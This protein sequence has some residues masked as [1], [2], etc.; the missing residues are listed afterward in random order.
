MMCKLTFS[1]AASAIPI[2]IRQEMNGTARFIRLSLDMKLS[3]KSLKSARMSK[4][5]KS[6]MLSQW[7][8]WWIPVENAQV[9]R[10]PGSFC[11]QFTI[12]PSKKGGGQLGFSAGDSRNRGQY[13]AR[14]AD[15]IESRK[16]GGAVAVAGKTKSLQCLENQDY[17]MLKNTKLPIPML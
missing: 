16:L 9:A 4:T 1:I 3:E 13:G 11:H 15:W 5:L 2:S 17:E 10:I 7:A 8:A 14:I 12:L 6:E